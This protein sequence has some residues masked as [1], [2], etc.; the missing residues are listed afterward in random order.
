MRRDIQFLRGIAVLS[1]VLYHAELFSLENG[2]L[3]VDVFF[4]ISGFLITGL[5]LRGLDSGQF[6]FGDFYLRRAR[7]LLPALYSTLFMTT[8]LAYFLLT[9]RQWGDYLDQLF[10]ALS[11][12]ANMVLPFQVGYFEDAA[13]S[14]PLLHIWS[15]SLEEQYYFLMPALL[16]LTSKRLRAPVMLA[17]AAGSLLLCV[18]WLG[19][20]E[21]WLGLDG[22]ELA[23][24]FFPARAWELLTGSL[25][26]WV[27]L[28]YPALRVPA[29]IKWLALL[30]LLALMGFSLDAVHPRGDAVLAIALTA[31]LIAGSD[32]WL[33]DVLPLRWVERVGDWS[34][35]LYLI[36]WPLLSFAYIAYLGEVPG[37]AKVALVLISLLLS[38]L[39]YRLVETPFRKPRGGAGR[40]ITGLLATTGLLLAIALPAASVQWGWRDSGEAD[41][42]NLRKKNVGLHRS[43]VLQPP[44]AIPGK[45]RTTEQ[46]K[47]AVWGDSYA[48]HLIPGLLQNPATGRSI[49]QLTRSGCTPGARVVVMVG[50]RKRAQ[51]C[52]DFN[53]RMLRF[54]L[55]TPTVESVVLSSPFGNFLK[56]W[57]QVLS[58]DELVP[59]DQQLV[60]RDLVR[61]VLQLQRA[62]KQV[63]IVSPP[64]HPGFDIGECVEREATGALVLGRTSCNFSLEGHLFRQRMVVGGLQRV[65]ARTQVPILWLSDLMCRDG[66]CEA[67]RGGVPL[68]R[69]RGH[70]SI[71]GSELLLRNVDLW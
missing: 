10:G 26:A 5:I 2:F 63:L 12:T 29:L 56:H 49:V 15:L 42:E 61:V 53:Q 21:K 4:V 43:C 58:D 71:V 14:K 11:F 57:K 35:S 30:A 36:H 16:A 64:P 38:F 50:D 3:G 34:Y 52:R 7:R 33:P 27:V 45:C 54:L 19:S 59:Y 6:S 70:L 9:Q 66:V 8:L 37:F 39:Q 40:S 68:Y 41:W 28:R 51:N 46:P 44:F 65:V 31:L 20:N 22:R 69:D 23:F 18:H 13:E 55:R 47:V 48:M 62:G 60:V 32:D 25:L 1:V 17:L 24:Y 67:S